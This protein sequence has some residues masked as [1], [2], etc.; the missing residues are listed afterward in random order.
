MHKLDMFFT[1]YLSPL[2]A[3]M[4]AVV[5]T[6]DPRHAGL[7]GMLRYHLGWTDAE[8]NSCQTRTGKHVRPVLCLLACEACGGEWEQALPAAAAIELL[9]NFSLIHD[10]I[11][12]RD[13]T[14]R[15]RLTVWALWGE[16]QAINA[17]DA[18]SIL[19]QLA[20]LR[21]SERNVPATT[22]V[23]ALHL[24]NHACLAI[25]NGQYLDIGFEHCASV[26]IADYL[27]MI[28]RKTAALAACACEIGALIAAAPDTR[29]E[30]LRTFG[31]H[32][33]LAFQM[34]DDVLGVW[35]DPAIT[36]KPVGADVARRKKSLPILYG[37]K[38]S[39]ELRALLAQER[40]STANV[41]YATEL[42]QE[43]GSRAYAERLTREH[44]VQALA[45]LEE[46]HLEGPAAEAL[47]ELA[48]T[49]LSRER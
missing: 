30:R 8:F 43:T 40:L 38:H 42:L 27:A 6:A 18:L 5:Q 48:Q 12:D 44:H 31:R 28:E 11:E 24:F 49:L 35:G 36:G 17:G 20:L 34:R 15:G 45:A 32:L 7:F 41:R 26:S 13:K 2:E 33:G 10:D 39:A 25:T 21:L 46:A 22:V 37:L 4:R 47:H 3:E 9:H 1:R 19:A 16:A 29:R 23:A 14:R